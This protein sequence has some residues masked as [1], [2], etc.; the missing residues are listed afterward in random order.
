MNT[1]RR[2]VSQMATP[3][4]R[5]RGNPLR[6]RAREFTKRDLEILLII[7]NWR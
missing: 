6:A 3:I 4:K 5:S 7:R 1:M 2:E